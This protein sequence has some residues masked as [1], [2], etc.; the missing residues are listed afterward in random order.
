MIVSATG[1]KSLP[2]RPCQGQQ[3]QEHEADDQDAGTDRP[4]HLHNRAIDDVQLR[5]RLAVH[6]LQPADRVLNYYHRGVHQHAERNRE[7]AEA[8]QVGGEAG[9]AHQDEREQRRQRQGRRDDQRCARLAEEHQQQQHDQHRGLDQRAHHGTDCP[10]D[11]FAAVVEHLDLDA[12]RKRRLDF[13]E[14]GFH[15]RHDVAR[16]CATR[17]RS[18][19]LRPP[20][21]SR[22]WSPRHTWSACHAAPRQCRRSAP[23][24]QARC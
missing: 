8:H 17:G 11:Q 2:S 14:L 5:H 12:G 15:A 23:R 4:H 20:L 10:V 19:G 21:L 16:I 24:R 7:P 22:P 6:G 9:G 3:R 18:P 13:R 1:E